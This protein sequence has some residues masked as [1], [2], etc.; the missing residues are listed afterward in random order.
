MFRAFCFW[1]LQQGFH[2]PLPNRQVFR[3]LQLS[4]TSTSGCVKIR[5]IGRF[6]N[7]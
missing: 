7:E 6:R 3:R 5:P 1:P 4:L 2:R